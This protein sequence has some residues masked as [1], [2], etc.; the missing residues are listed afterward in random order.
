MGLRFIDDGWRHLHRSWAVRVSLAYGTFAGVA[1]AL[2]AFFEVFSPWFILL[3]GVVVNVALI[4]LARLV[5]QADL[6][7]PAA[8]APEPAHV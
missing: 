6:P 3:I 5:K 1:L 4:P 7:P 8:P 2:P